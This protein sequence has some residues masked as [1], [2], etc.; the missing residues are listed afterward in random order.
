MKKNDS[1]IDF[2]NKN[3]PEHQIIYSNCNVHARRYFSDAVKSTDS[4]TAK[5]ANG[6]NPEDYLRCLF[7]K[8]PYAE[9]QA[10]WQKLLPWNIEITPFKMRGEWVE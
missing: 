9:T 2:W 1:A 3:H 5:E 4:K 7:E 6:L 8:A 10:D